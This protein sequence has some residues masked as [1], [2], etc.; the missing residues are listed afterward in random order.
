VLADWSVTSPWIEAIQKC[1]KFYVE[2]VILLGI[3]LWQVRILRK[4]RVFAQRV[5]YICNPGYET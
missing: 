4:Q 3:F 5:T 1:V 2:R